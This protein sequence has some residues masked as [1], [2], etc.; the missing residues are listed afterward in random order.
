ML[1]KSSVTVRLRAA[2]VGL[3][4]VLGLVVA[5]PAPAEAAPKAP[6]G[7]TRASYS[8]N[9]VRLTWK[10]VKGAAAYQVKYASN[11]KL[12]KASYVT[13]AAPVAEIGG[14]KAS[15]NYYFKVKALKA[16]GKALTKYSKTK[17]IKTSSTKAYTVLSPSGLALKA[18]YGDQVN[19]AWTAQG[20]TNR[21]RVNWS[22]SKSMKKAKAVYVTGPNAAIGGL[23]RSKNYYFTVQVS[24]AGTKAISPA[25]TVL[26]VKTRKTVTAASPMAT[27]SRVEPTA[28]TVSWKPARTAPAYEVVYSATNWADSSRVV[29]AGTSVKVQGVFAKSTYQV[30]VRALDSANKPVGGFSTVASVTTPS[31]E[32]SLRLASYNVRCFD[33]KPK[34]QSGTPIVDLP[35]TQRRSL[36]AQNIGEA[37]PDVIALQEAQQAELGDGSKL[38]Q[39][40]DLLLAMNEQLGGVW[41]LTND[42]EYNCVKS[43]TPTACEPKDQ[44]ASKGVRIAYRIDR[45]AILREN[46]VD[47]TGSMLLPT[48]PAD[49]SGASLKASERYM[50][51][52]FMQQL[53]TKKTFLMVDVHLESRDDATSSSAGDAG[54]G[55]TANPICGKLRVEQAQAIVA[56]IAQLNTDGVPVVVAGDFS[57]SRSE[58]SKLFPSDVFTASGLVNPL[59]GIEKYYDP[60]AVPANTRINI[61]YNS[62]NQLERTP[63]RY[64]SDP[65]K[66]NTYNGAYNDYILTSPMA[67][68]DFEQL[69]H[70]NGDGTYADQQFASDHNLI[71]TT[72]RLP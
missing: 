38:N 47:R 67:V 1:P 39:Y 16:D 69:V 37:N 33:C 40:Q 56:K 34:S 53:T 42:R 19:L 24:S 55:D 59:G 64:G 6:S 46:G 2:L 21:Y 71:R 54:C 44:G 57:S 4:L 26:K 20:S 61:V 10:A 65:A 49:G 45:L 23:S 43:T 50:V 51:W 8:N 62:V 48:A 30:K 58:A 5:N 60:D 32:E 13:V 17:K 12:K 28:F 9:A 72:V 27:V 68:Y 52:A 41:K 66:N 25:T 35:W 70:L 14:L 36:V 22:T 18:N 63:R 29:A 15:K 11:S 7:L 3:A 31:G